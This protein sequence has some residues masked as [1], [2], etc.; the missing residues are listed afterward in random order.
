MDL[1]DIMQKAQA[2]QKDLEAKQ[3]EIK[4]K[5]VKGTAGVDAVEVTMSC[6]YVVK[7]IKI[8]DDVLDLS[9]PESKIVLHELI[10]AATNDA[11]AKVAEEI[12]NNVAIP[13]GSGLDIASIFSKDDK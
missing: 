1:N 10:Q 3:K 2:M 12:K 13:D 4:K 8:H 6:N 7:E 9:D 5:T 11:L